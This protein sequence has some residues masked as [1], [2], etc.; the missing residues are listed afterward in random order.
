M[1]KEK[2]DR[3]LDLVGSSAGS[4]IS[5]A[6]WCAL[7]ASSVDVIMGAINERMQ[8]P[9]TSASTRCALLYV[10]HELL[11][12]CAA[13]G[14]PE[15]GKRR[16]L[17]AVSRVIPEAVTAVRALSPADSDEFERG[18]SKV[19]SWWSLLNI[20]PRVWIDQLGARNDEVPS[21]ESVA[22]ASMSAQLRYIAGLMS[23]YNEAK[24]EWLRALQTSPE[25]AATLRGEAQQWLASVRAAVENKLEGGGSLAT[26]LSAELSV[27]TGSAPNPGGSFVGKEE[28]DDVLGSFFQ[29][30]K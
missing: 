2:V 27:L 12:T 5:V 6:T 15:A 10:V 21:S 13:N 28:E 24:E 19:A 16:V 4:I 25:R 9:A 11:L 17:T 23:R 29:K 1:N 20:F 18:L 3:R 30:G 22:G 26:W 8:D 14:V 7:H